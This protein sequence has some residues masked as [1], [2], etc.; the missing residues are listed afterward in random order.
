MF[1]AHERDDRLV[2]QQEWNSFIPDSLGARAPRHALSRYL[3]HV[4]EWPA[5][6]TSPLLDFNKDVRSNAISSVFAGAGPLGLIS[7]DS[8][9]ETAPNQ[10]QRMS[11]KL[12]ISPSSLLLRV[13]SS[14][15]TPSLASCRAGTVPSGGGFF[16]P[17]PLVFRPR[18]SEA[19][20]QG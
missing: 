4:S 14:L 11:Q 13:P 18:T 19:F 12:T 3:S 5:A 15:V 8:C 1:G 16:A 7:C 17:H 10:E 20:E 2:Q 6:P 9:L